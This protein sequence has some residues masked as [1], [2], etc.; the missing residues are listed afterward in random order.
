MALPGASLG[1]L[2]SPHFT[3]TTLLGGTN[4]ERDTLGRLFASQIAGFL[5]L[6]NPEEK[7]TLLLGLGLERRESHREGFFDIME[8]VQQ[9]S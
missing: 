3:P 9:V 1:S 8:L 2:P 7:R 4:E 6:A 5:T